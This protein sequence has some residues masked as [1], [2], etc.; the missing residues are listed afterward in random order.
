ME[1]NDTPLSSAPVT[2]SDTQID[3]SEY[4]KITTEG[5][6]EK[7]SI[8]PDTQKKIEYLLLRL[9]FVA[10]MISFVCF[11]VLFCF[12]GYTWSRNQTQNSWIMKQTKYVYQ[13]SAICNWVSWGNTQA[14][15]PSSDFLDFLEKNPRKDLNINLKELLSN[16]TCL[17][18]D[19]LS[20]VLW[21][22]EQF[23]KE[24]LKEAYETTII[25]KFLG[26]TLESSDEINTILALDPENRI[27]HNEI[28]KL[29][30]KTVTQNSIKGKSTVTC[31]DIKFQWLTTSF[32]CSIK[33]I[34][35]IQPRDEAIKFLENLEKTE[36][37]LVSYPSSLDLKVDTKNNILSTS[38][39]VNVTYVP[40]RY[41]SEFL[42]KI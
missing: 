29:I 17:T 39:W 23:L 37:L 38:F 25:K 18:P 19:T 3:L 26:S 13:W 5:Y 30:D 32:S 22:Q 15:E 28:L 34:P 27:K 24:K 40:A 2:N 35:P 33:S 6:Q 12:I 21:M 16:K 7:G 10:K 31:W 42:K 36:R 1:T 8:E 14:I 11:T 41:E 20:H 4:E 9:I